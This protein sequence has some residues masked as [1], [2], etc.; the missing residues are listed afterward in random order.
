VLTTEQNDYLC[1]TD[2]GTPMGD[3]FRRYW[4]PVLLAE[5]IAEPDGPPVRV[6]IMGER[7]IAFRDT[8]GRIG[9]IAEF[10]AHRGVSL[11]FGRNEE[12]GLRCAY[13]GWKYDVEGNCLEVP[14]EQGTGFERTMKLTAYPC[15]EQ[16]GAIWAFMGP[17]DQRPA[18]P[19]LEW[20]VLPQAH[21]FVTKR[22]QEC[23]YLQAM[24]GGI[25]SSHVSWLHSHNLH[26]DPMFVG[27]KGNLYNMQDPNP[28]FEVV[29]APGGLYV[30][31]RRNAEADSFYWRITQ[32]I[33]PWH[34]IIPPRADHPFGAHAWVPIDDENCW[35]WS[36][37]YHP[38]KALSA[39]QLDAMRN[40]A[41]IHVKYVPGT[42]IPL[43][44]KSNDYLI[45]R[46]AQ[47]AG[48][49]YSGVDGI[50]MQ[51]ASLQE[52][53][54]PI[55]DRTKEKLVSTDSGIIMAR[56]K[57]WRAVEELRDNGVTPPGVNPKHQRVRSVSIVLPK[58]ANF[59][60]SCRDALAVQPGTRH[61]SV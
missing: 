44:N 35:A 10:C 39:P 56:R 51:D 1:Q 17:P 30:G 25:D 54:G 3:L 38:H 46:K 57:L 31:A 26:R 19:A 53:M 59:V 61:A 55:V 42:F 50:A 21:V 18:P 58:D 4:V 27:S 36:I 23:N 43:A 16:G 32:W 48:G 33:M 37:N 20:T 49:G 29:D 12:C 6:K 7:L 5:E 34:T 40:G 41:G 14:Q 22:L 13:H 45:D 2:R 9:L 28:V 24:E 11:F 15:I 52:S 8:K 60:D 47:K